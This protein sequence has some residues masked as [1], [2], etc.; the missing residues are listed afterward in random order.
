MQHM[1]NFN[2]GQ[3][4]SSHIDHTVKSKQEIRW[5]KIRMSVQEYQVAFWN[6]LEL[7]VYL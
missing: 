4:N 1:T 6:V 5:S 7:N 2:F 3:V